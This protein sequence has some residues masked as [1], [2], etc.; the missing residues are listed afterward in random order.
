MDY[1]NVMV[2][3]NNFN[4]NMTKDKNRCFGKSSPNHVKILMGFFLFKLAVSHKVR[5][6][7]QTFCKAL[8][9]IIYHTGFMYTY[10]M[11]RSD[12]VDENLIL[13]LILVKI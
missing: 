2:V 7:Q 5:F 10:H 8:F 11:R 6:I 4:F 3:F 13:N 1:L 9:F 12:D